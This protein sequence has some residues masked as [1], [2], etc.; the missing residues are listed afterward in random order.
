MFILISGLPGAGKS[1]FADAVE[2]LKLGFIH[3]PL[4]KY[5]REVPEEGV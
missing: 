1:T 5:I 2:S 3:L 4:D